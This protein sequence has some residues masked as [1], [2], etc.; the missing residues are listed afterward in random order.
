MGSIPGWGI[1]MPYATQYKQKKKQK[2]KKKN[3][4]LE[5]WSFNSFALHFSFSDGQT[6]VLNM[7]IWVR[8]QK[9]QSHFYMHVGSERSFS[10]FSGVGENSS[11]GLRGLSYLCLWQVSEVGKISEGTQEV[12]QVFIKLTQSLPFF[13][14]TY[15][16]PLF[17]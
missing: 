14:H 17:L 15:V 7:Q 8:K 9:G 12:K 5:A 6:G 16:N 2:K 4:A 11:D 3:P 10:I 1:K 13:S